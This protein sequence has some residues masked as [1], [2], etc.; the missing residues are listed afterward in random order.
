MITK[1]CY[2]S[3]HRQIEVGDR[4]AVKLRQW[5][6]FQ[7]WKKGTVSHVNDPDAPKTL[8]RDMRGLN[9]PVVEVKLDDDSIAVV[10]HPFEEMILLS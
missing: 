6:I 3:T 10:G 2:Y 9:D 8:E 5:L 7:K 1:Y 4:V